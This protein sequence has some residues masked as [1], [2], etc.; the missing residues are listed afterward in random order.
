MSKQLAPIG[1]DYTIVL[2]S[3][4]DLYQAGEPNDYD[5]QTRFESKYRSEAAELA[6]ELGVSIRVIAGT[7]DGP[8]MQNQT[9]HGDEG[10]IWQ[11][12]H[13]RVC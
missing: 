6:S 4:F 7:Y 5:A 1:D 10:D 13:D 8:A 11:A 2:D 3:S 9:S 12:I